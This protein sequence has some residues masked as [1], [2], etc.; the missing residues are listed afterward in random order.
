MTLR[1]EPVTA[2]VDASPGELAMVLV[3]LHNEGTRAETILASPVGLDAPAGGEWSDQPFTVDAGSSVRAAIRVPVPSSLGIGQHAAGIQLQQGDELPVLIGFTVSIA[4]VRHVDLRAT[5]SPVR[6]RKSAKFDL[7]IVNNETHLVQLAL[8]ADEPDVRV[9]FKQGEF[10]LQ[11]GEQARTRGKVKG[12]T[13]LAGDT[14]QHNVQL[15]ARGKATSTSVQLPF[16]QRPLL[17]RRMRSVVAALLVVAIWIGAAFVVFWRVRDDGGDQA[18][19]DT[20]VTTP[21]AVD[22]GDGGSG[23]GDGG[24]GSGDGSADGAGDA[25]GGGEGSGDGAGGP[26][27]GAGGS[28]DGSDAGGTDGAGDGAGGTGDGAGDADGDGADGDGDGDGVADGAGQATVVVNGTL[29]IDRDPEGVTITPSPMSLQDLAEADPGTT[30]FA[31]RDRPPA[32]KIWSARRGFRAVAPTV[33]QSQ[34]IRAGAFAPDAD[35][36]WKVELPINQT[37][38]LAFTKQGYQPQ[39]FVVSPEAGDRIELAVELEPAT[40]ELAGTVTGGGR[41]LENVTIIVTDGLFDYETVTDADGVWGIAAVASG[42]QYTVLATLEGFGADAE[43]VAVVPGEPPGPIDLVLEFGRTVLSGSVIDSVTRQ[44]LPGVTVTAINGTETRTT[45]TLTDGAVGTFQIPELTAGARYSITAELEGYRTATTSR[46]MGSGLTTLAPLELVP[47]AATLGGTIV[48]TSA[49]PIARAGIELTRDDLPAPVAFVQSVEDGTF[50]LGKVPPGR[51]LLT[52]RHWQHATIRHVLVVESATSATLDPDDALGRQSG[53]SFTLTM[54]PEP[55]D[56]IGQRPTGSLTLRIRD[57]DEARELFP[58]NAVDCRDQPG[59]PLVLRTEEQ[60]LAIFCA[61]VEVITSDQALI[62]AAEAGN[63]PFTRVEPGGGREPYYRFTCDQGGGDACNSLANWPGYTIRNIPVGTYS[64]RIS[65]PDYNPRT[66]P[67]TIRVGGND[68]GVVNLARLGEVVGTVIDSSLLPAEVSILGTSGVTV[69]IINADNPAVSYLTRIIDGTF[70]TDDEARLPP[71]RYRVEVRAFADG[72]YIDPDQDVDGTPVTA[73]MEF[74]IAAPNF[75]DPTPS[76]VELEPILADPYPEITVRVFEPA[77]PDGVTSAVTFSDIAATPT[78][79]MT[80]ASEAGAGA[81]TGQVT[82]STVAF[83]KAAVASLDLTE[84]GQLAT[85]TVAVGSEP[86]GVHEGFSYTFGGVDALGAPIERL[87]LAGDRYLDVGLI[88]VSP[89][90]TF[91]I[92]AGTLAWIDEGQTPDQSLP[93]NGAT[94]TASNV[95]TALLAAD[96]S[97]APTSS[98]AGVTIHTPTIAPTTAIVNLSGEATWSFPGVRQLVGEARFDITATGFPGGSLFVTIDAEGVQTSRVEMDPEIVDDTDIADGSFDIV[99]EPSAGT[100]RGRATIFTSDPDPQSTAVAV[101]ISHNGSTIAPPVTDDGPTGTYSRS[102]DAGTWATTA[103]APSGHEFIGVD[104]EQLVSC[105]P[106]GQ[107]APNQAVFTAS[108]AQLRQCVPPGGLSAEAQFRLVELG[109]LTVNVEDLGENPIDAATNPIVHRLDGVAQTDSTSPTLTFGGLSVPTTVDPPDYPAAP[110]LTQTHTFEITRAGQYDPTSATVQVYRI[111]NDS[112]STLIPVG[113]P[114]SNVN[115]TGPFP[116]PFEPGAKYVVD[117]RLPTLGAVT[118]TVAATDG[119]ANPVPICAPGDPSPEQAI[120]TG[121]PVRLEQLVL[122]FS[123]QPV[124]VVDYVDPF[125]QPTGRTDI[126]TTTCDDFTLFGPEGLYVLTVTHSEFTSSRSSFTA[127]APVVGSIDAYPPEVVP[128]NGIVRPATEPVPT[129]TLRRS[130][131]DIQA[132]T[133]LGGAAAPNAYFIISR[134][135]GTPSAPAAVVAG[136]EGPYDPG[137]GYEVEVRSCAS[138]PTTQVEFAACVERFPAILTF[139][140]PRTSGAPPT[141]T[142]LELPLL[143][144]GGEIDVVLTFENQRMRPVCPNDQTV[145][146]D[147]GYLDAITG[148]VDGNDQT[149]ADD[150]AS[151]NHQAATT[152]AADQTGCLTAPAGV[153]TVTFDALIPT[154]THRLTLPP[155][156]GFGAP[157]LLW[158][159]DP[160]DGNAPVAIAA[161]DSSGSYEFDVDVT[162]LSE[163]STA[164]V[165]YVATPVT[166][167]VW[168]CGGTA[169]DPRC[170]ERFPNLEATLT[171]PGGGASID[172]DEARRDR[173]D[174]YL[175]TFADVHPDAQAYDLAITDRLHDGSPIQPVLVQPGLQGPA[176]DYFFQGTG[177]RVA[178]RVLLDNTA[179]PDDD[180]VPGDATVSLLGRYTGDTNYT[181]ISDVPVACTI[182]EDVGPIAYLCFDDDS[183]P[184]FDD[185]FVVVAK[186]S[187]VT[188]TLEFI[189]LNEGETVFREVTL[190]KRARL[191]VTAVAFD[192]AGQQTVTFPAALFDLV[193]LVVDSD[194]STDGI[195]PIS[196]PQFC[197]RAAGC[198]QFYA[199][200]GVTYR[201]ETGPTTGYLPASTATIAATVGMTPATQGG[202]PTLTF[203]PRV[204]AV[205]VDGT[206]LTIAGVDLTIP[207]GGTTF[208]DTTSPYRFTSLDASPI[209]LTGEG[210]ALIRVTNGRNREVATTALPGPITVLPYQVVRGT[211]ALNVPVGTTVRATFTGATAGQE[212]TTTVLANR[213]F[214]FTGAAG[215]DVNA[216]GSD[217]EWTISLD[218]T[219]SSSA[220]VD[221]DATTAADIT[222]PGAFT[223][224]TTTTTSTTTTTVPPTTTTTSPPTTTTTTTTSTTTTSSSVAPPTTT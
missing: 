137:T 216:D 16:I 22:G 185:Y 37:Y 7:D 26:G 201:F 160:D 119:S 212:R 43:I 27:D 6:G 141:T 114:V 133:A 134:N 12:P 82:G 162:Q 63:A 59:A 61:D 144:V 66:I 150:P 38:E 165:T 17:A 181:F 125:G 204:I 197:D 192:A 101:S 128:G 199:D 200:P 42:T 19:G 218:A 98:A 117:V 79:T 105:L 164:T 94:I 25:D 87:A 8:E 166:V 152:F 189:G 15:V 85:C 118:G 14:I 72:Y 177:V 217:L 56:E 92:P 11:P 130:Q 121:V 191:Q 36:I 39:S 110:T 207:A 115:L 83:S 18:G 195:D 52:V 74:V 47:L 13:R 221:V 65:H 214:V 145:T 182:D 183:D 71:G 215:L 44:G 151:R 140:V 31:V 102:V 100:I 35:G 4:S 54:R 149:L 163:T 95:V 203:Q 129:L 123:V 51:Y 176:Q 2:V 111:L 50:T 126:S 148:R 211:V 20:P 158:D 161:D 86:A 173:D 1:I 64:V 24:D 146:V 41:P 196:N 68:P 187:Y 53:P 48:D 30:S 171:E 186:D 103:A 127:T 120:V 21:G 3:D 136:A 206:G 213:T 33:V 97:D 73:P 169:G 112:L 132:V 106:P 62:D 178:V 139:S 167:Q 154:G 109:S 34:T 143:E 153:R 147:Q 29:D 157:T 179:D 23:V 70:Q 69:R 57:A 32:K 84:D 58:D 168:I 138:P 190:L 224:P 220:T 205:G 184:Q 193:D 40:E 198:F 188:E 104:P 174:G 55:P 116:L 5:P 28:G 9:R 76:R 10:S 60:R 91:R 99:L 156:A 155:V 67:V 107:T 46:L 77:T 180:P 108:S 90:P 88:K 78:A 89:A 113:G 81:L 159:R 75:I 172:G 96:L 122:P 93:V 208:T 209:P 222:I 131:V 194:G 219:G 49:A 45:T 135:G 80:C 142:V 202:I 210:V 124:P 170:G 223:V 175:V